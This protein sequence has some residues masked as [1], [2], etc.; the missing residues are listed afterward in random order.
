MP[1]YQAVSLFVGFFLQ[2]QPSN[3]D[4]NRPFWP[5]VLFF[6]GSIIHTWSNGHDAIGMQGYMGVVENGYTGTWNLWKVRL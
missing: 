5:M 3:S 4:I 6:H 2:I 1:C